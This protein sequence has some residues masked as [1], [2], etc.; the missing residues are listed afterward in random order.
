[1]D[2]GSPA[3]LARRISAGS[4]VMLMTNAISMLQPAI[5]PSSASSAVS[6][7]QE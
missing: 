5:S 3:G 4:R 1:M 7:R 2:R 6:R